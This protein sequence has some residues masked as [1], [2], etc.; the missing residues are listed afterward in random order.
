MNEQLQEQPLETPTK[1]AYAAEYLYQLQELIILKL[2]TVEGFADMYPG[3]E[4]DLR[5]ADPDQVI[6]LAYQMLLAMGLDPEEILDISDSSS[7]ALQRHFDYF[8]R[9]EAEQGESM[10]ADDRSQYVVALQR[11]A[12]GL[13]KDTRDS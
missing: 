12:E 4:E 5:E 7:T 2:R 8:I 13:V 6:A 1:E 10:S 3:W 11:L 9:L